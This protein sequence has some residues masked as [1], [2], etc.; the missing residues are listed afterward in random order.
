MASQI[1]TPHTPKG[2]FAPTPSGPLHLG[3]L[4]TALAGWLDMKARQGQWWV[5]I[6]DLDQTRA[7]PGAAD[8]QLRQL[9]AFGLHWD[10]HVLYQNT[11]LD[12]YQAALEQL[13]HSGHAFYCNLSRKQLAAFGN[14]HPGMDYAVDP[15]PETAVRIK[16]PPQPISFHDRFMGLQQFDLHQ[17]EGA[18]VIRRRDGFFAYQLGS[19]VDDSALGFTDVMRGDDLLPS[20]A[21]QCWIIDC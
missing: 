5:R 20:S 14:R 10:G 4:V 15:A 2:R 21:K 12:S 19:A 17:H 16:V 18:F 1:S 9:E 8:I 3:S 11:H 7:V 6:D 13:L